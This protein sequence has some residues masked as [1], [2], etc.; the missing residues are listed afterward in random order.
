MTPQSNQTNWASITHQQGEFEF[1]KDNFLVDFTHCFEPAIDVTASFQDRHA[2]CDALL[3]TTAAN[4]AQAPRW[5]PC[6]KIVI[7]MTSFSAAYATCPIR[8]GLSES[9]TYV[10][11]PLPKE[12]F[13]NATGAV[14]PGQRLSVKITDDRWGML[15]DTTA[16][17][18]GTASLIAMVLSLPIILDY[19][20]RGREHQEHPYDM[21]WRSCTCE[22]IFYTSNVIWYY[23][24]DWTNSC[25]VHAPSNI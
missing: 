25:Q 1:V 4:T 9:E 18:M 21:I 19:P 23:G 15:A 20:F 3:D 22:F 7:G 8:Q 5:K 13:T 16:A 17:M 14:P 6:S 10:A 11:S 24:S 2:R 12:L